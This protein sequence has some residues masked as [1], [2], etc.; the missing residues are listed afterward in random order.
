MER[1]SLFDADAFDFRIRPDQKEHIAAATEV[2]LRCIKLRERVAQ[3]SYAEDDLSE[4]WKLASDAPFILRSSTAQLSEKA[5]LGSSFLSSVV[6]DGRRPK[7]ANMLKA[8]TAIIETADDRLA[9]VDRKLSD[10]QV[11]WVTNPHPPGSRHIDRLQQDLF[12]LVRQLKTSNSLSDV[13]EIDTHLRVSLIA[14]LET[15]IAMLRTPLI[16]RG[17]VA[18]TGTALKEVS[19]KIASDSSAGFFGGLAGAAAL[20]LLTYFG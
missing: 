14:L 11:G 2:R 18:R 4:F 12:E 20:Q 17:L 13:P 19:V 6:R 7:L 9:D 1:E 10:D 16:E 3:G 8:L 15:T 5:E